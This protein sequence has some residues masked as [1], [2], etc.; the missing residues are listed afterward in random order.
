MAAMKRV[1]TTLGLV[2][3]CSLASTRAHAS[4][5]TFT[6]TNG[7]LSGSV[8]FSQVGDILT[9]VLTNTSIADVLAPN[10]ILTAVFFDLAGFPPGTLTPISAV[11]STGSVVWFDPTNGAYG[12]NV[13]GE[14]A[15]GSDLNNTPGSA[16]LGTSSSGL[17]LFGSGNFN[18]PNLQGPDSVN[19]LQ[20]GITAAGDD[21]LSGNVAVTGKNALI[22]NS[23]T[24][25]LQASQG[26]TLSGLSNVTF[27]YGTALS[28]PTVTATCTANCGDEPLAPIPEPASLVLLGSGLLGTAFGLRRRFGRQA[29]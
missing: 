16:V 29:R 20:Y 28:D 25:T 23:V 7:S 12:D 21:P 15:Y 14:W 27:Q 1:L 4:E 6:G 3:V 11:L 22:Y 18:G 8:T 24:F 2:A 13:G 9:I 17:S 19:G 26:F 5:I 10:Q